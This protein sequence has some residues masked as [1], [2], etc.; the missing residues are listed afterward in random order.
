MPNDVEVD[1]PRI[2]RTAPI[3]RT[4]TEERF[5]NSEGWKGAVVPGRILRPEGNGFRDA[6]R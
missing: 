5:V 1:I 2:V 3:A 6:D 4:P